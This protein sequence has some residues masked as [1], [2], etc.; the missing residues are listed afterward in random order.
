MKTDTTKHTPVPWIRRDASK[1]F[2]HELWYEPGD[3]L[4][5]LI[6]RTFTDTVCNKHQGS[7]LEN[8]EFI[9]D[10]CNNYERVKAERDK[11]R[12]ALNRATMIVNVVLAKLEAK[13]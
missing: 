4:R 3:G 10:A 12:S 7:G 8:A 11:L 2:Q 9:L 6:A 5:S 13:P 1:P